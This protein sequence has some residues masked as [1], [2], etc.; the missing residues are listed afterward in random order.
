MTELNAVR[1]VVWGV[2]ARG[3]SSRS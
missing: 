1:S 2:D 3:I